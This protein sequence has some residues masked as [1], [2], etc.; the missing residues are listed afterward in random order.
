MFFLLYPI[1]YFTIKFPEIRRNKFFFLDFRNFHRISQKH[2]NRTR[3]NHQKGVGHLDC[4]RFA[5]L[6]PDSLYR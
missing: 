6:L 4:G 2:R 5:D 1:F 3:K